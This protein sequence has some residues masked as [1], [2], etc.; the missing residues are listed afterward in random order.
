MIGLI[1]HGVSLDPEQRI[2]ARQGLAPHDLL[3]GVPAIVGRVAGADVDLVGGL[4]IEGGLVAVQGTRGA[5]LDGLVVV[6]VGQVAAAL[7]VVGSAL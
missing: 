1:Q 6:A 5:D 3:V 2:L 4:G 7:V